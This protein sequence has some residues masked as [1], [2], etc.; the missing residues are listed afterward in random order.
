MRTILLVLPCILLSLMTSTRAT[1]QA[2]VVLYNARIYTMDPQQPAAEALAIRGD[3]FLMVGTDRE[4]LDAYP[5][6]R[7][8]DAAGR[9][10]VPGFVD[11]HVHLMGVA[12]GFL[13]ADLVGTSSKEEVIERLH[14]FQEALPPDAWLLGRGWDQNDWPRTEFPTRGDLDAAF[15]ERPVWLRRI[16]GHAGWANTAALEAAG[17]DALRNVRDP[18]GG[19]IVRDARGVPTGLFIDTAMRMVDAAVP[20]FTDEQQDRALQRAI[21]EANRYGLTA[22]HDAGIDAE[23]ITRYRRAIDEDRFDLRV[24]AMIGGSGTTFDQFCER[25]PLLDYGGRLTVRSVKLYI[26]GALGSRGAALLDEYADDPGNEGLLRTSPT[27][28]ARRVQRALEC[29]FQVNTHAIGDE[30]NRVVLDAYEQAMQATGRTLGRHRIEHAQVVASEDLPRFAALGV[31]ASMQPTHATSDMYWA[32]ERLGPQRIEGAYA[33]RS[34]L[35]H[36]VHLAFGSDAPVESI[37]PL[38]G[39]Y[40]ATTRQDADGWPEGGWVPAQRLTREEALRA[41]TIDAAYAAFQEETTGSITPGK[42]ADFVLLSRDIMT[43][44]ASELLETEVVATYL[45]GKPVYER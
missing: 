19:R 38:L 18:A 9:T 16:D 36:G 39:I 37:D 34:F 40:A 15:P 20:P 24:Y 6:A 29:G 41:F 13:Q 44:P 23:T 14:A 21:D 28:F 27:A 12:E 22:V 25:G 33:W 4:V 42:Y 31:V 35:E 5:A 8:I 17:L 3:R 43:V 45:G 1:A 2:D 7:R 32:E 10:V 11:A 30:G 26:D